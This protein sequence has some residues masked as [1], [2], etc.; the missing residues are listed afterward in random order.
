MKGV[1]PGVVAKVKAESWKD[2][3]DSPALEIMLL[4][5]G[6]ARVKVAARL[7]PRVSKPVADLDPDAA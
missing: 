1:V 5:L 7:E 2:S 6:G 3:R 4:R